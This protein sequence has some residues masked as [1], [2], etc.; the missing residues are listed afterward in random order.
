VNVAEDKVTI[1]RRNVGVCHH[2]EVG[3]NVSFFSFLPSF[4]RIPFFCF[5]FFLFLIHNITTKT[6][7]FRGWSQ[8]QDPKGR[9]NCAPHSHQKEGSFTRSLT[10]PSFGFHSL[11]LKPFLCQIEG[12]PER[13]RLSVFRSNKHL[14]VQVIDDTSMHTL[15]SASTMQKTISEE[16]NYSAGPTLVSSLEMSYM[17]LWFCCCLM[18]S[19]LARKLINFPFSD[20]KTM[21][22]LPP[23]T[24]MVSQ[25]LI[26]CFCL[27]FWKPLFCLGIFYIPELSSPCLTTYV[28]VELLV[29][30]SNWGR[31]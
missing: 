26:F 2:C 8:S 25:L 14:S 19:A 4:L 29:D 11:K 7:I 17:L 9:Q 21:V 5:F 10:F 23:M 22:L 12:T 18:S 20:W 30:M 27:W 31:G 1:N 6:Q 13:P 15:A 16:F 24:Q 28:A 3:N